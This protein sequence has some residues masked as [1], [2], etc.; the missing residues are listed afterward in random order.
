MNLCLAFSD[1][2]KK[3]I[4]FLKEVSLPLL[5]VPTVLGLGLNSGCKAAPDSG[6]E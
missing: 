6:G 4:P 1:P 5:S 3:T 2:L